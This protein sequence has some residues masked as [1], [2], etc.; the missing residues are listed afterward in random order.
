[1]EADH[2]MLAQLPN[3]TAQLGCCT[4]ASLSIQS[5]HVLFVCCF[6][7]HV[8]CSRDLAWVISTAAMA[9]GTTE[10]RQLPDQRLP[11]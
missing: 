9:G 6:A 1:M 5:A 10:T 3:A 2:C 4:E 7:M 11:A 8:E